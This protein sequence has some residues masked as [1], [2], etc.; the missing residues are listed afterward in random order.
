M[1]PKAIN[2]ILLLFF[3]AQLTFS[4]DDSLKVTKSDTSYTTVANSKIFSMLKKGKAPK[5]TLQLS[6]NYDIGHLD[7]AGDENTQFRRADFESGSSFGTRYGYGVSLTGK[8]ALHK[9]GNVRL[10]VTTAYNRFQ[11]N[12][13]YQNHRKEEWYTMFFQRLWELKIIFL[14]QRNSNRSLDSILI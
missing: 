8:I 12:L 1:I 4:Q 11:S 7:L 13:L 9:A 10:N 3:A 2:I 5:L 6:F 14:P